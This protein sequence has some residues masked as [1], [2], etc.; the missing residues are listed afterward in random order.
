MSR[1]RRQAGTLLLLLALPVRAQFDRIAATDDGSRIYFTTPMQLKGAAPSRWP[2]SRLYRFGLDGVTLFAERGELAPQNS[3]GSGDGV[4][5]PS[6]SADGSVVGFTLSGI[7]SAP[8]CRQTTGRTEVRGRETLDLGPGQVQISRNGRWAL[9]IRETF[10]SA[11]GSMSVN[12]VTTLTLA[13]LSTGVRSILQL[14]PTYAPGFVPLAILSSDGGVLGARPGSAVGIGGVAVPVYGVLKQDVFTPIPLPSGSRLRPFAL[15]DDG[16][17]ALAHD[18]PGDASAFVVRLVSVSLAS[19]AVST[20]VESRE[21]GSFP[22]YLAHSADGKR[23]LY[24]VPPSSWFYGAALLWD[25]AT[26]TSIPV[27][28]ESGELAVAAALPGS[29]S[30]AFL[31]TTHGRIVR[32]DVSSRSV[33]PL[34]PQT[35]YCDVPSPI[36]AG[37]FTRLHCSFGGS[38]AELQGKLIFDATAAPVLYSVPGEIGIQAPW[39]SWSGVPRLT[40]DI[41]SAS[42]FRPS[43]DVQVYDGA[44]AI[45]AAEGGLFGTAMVK[46]DW[47]GLVTQAPAPGEI[48]HL[49][50][51]GLGW[52][53]SPEVTGTPASLLKPNP[54]QW[55]LSCELLPRRETFELLFAGAAPG[56]TGVYQTTFRM[57]ARSAVPATGLEC[58]LG[59]P[60]MS[61]A[62]GPG[63]PVRGVYGSGQVITIPI[64]PR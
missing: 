1:P 56:M 6:V 3:F 22:T 51:T 46:G 54:I 13:D 41:D 42:P 61:A 18:Y 24:S 48:F 31:S 33:S 44:P 43:M 20:I 57:P 53:E 55:A 25:A 45:L 21:P 5:F 36:A 52:L 32:Y 30:I 62:F 58:V 9:V 63:I 27:P 29:G 23:V 28:L 19:G 16:G 34:F 60:V 35:P 49:Y 26:N 39:E 17:T 11:P 50:M 47:S 8:D 12:I 38:P 2:E 4:T 59:S 64:G 40:L 15:S 7:C 14:S 10:E 37:S